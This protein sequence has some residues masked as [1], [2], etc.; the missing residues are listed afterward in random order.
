M[1]VKK[2]AP[3]NRT[4]T[5]TPAERRI[6]SRRLLRLTAPV[7][8]GRLE[9]RIIR[10]D[11]FEVLP[12]LPRNFVDLLFVDPPYNI[13]R[14]YRDSAFRRLSHDGYALW[15]DRW[16]SGLLPVLK[17]TASVYI[18]ADWRSS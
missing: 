4:L 16:L 2:P 15:M 8:A 11:L 12:F 10:Q 5:L 9:N 1:S 17:R 18:C 6:Y 7:T 3:R 13:S 14:R